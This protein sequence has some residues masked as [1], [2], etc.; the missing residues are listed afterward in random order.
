MDAA[1]VCPA[2]EAA[3]EELAVGVCGRGDRVRGLGS[4]LSQAARTEAAIE[5]W[6]K[7]RRESWGK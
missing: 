7:R 5:A 4:A 3:S 2:D 1:I 6:R